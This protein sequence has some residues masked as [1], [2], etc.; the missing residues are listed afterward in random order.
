M[1]PLGPIPIE[2]IQ[3]ARERLVGTALRTPLLRLDV[4]DA[5]AEIWLKPEN[6][7]PGAGK[8]V[9]VISGGNIDA[10]KLATILS[11]SIP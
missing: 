11:G 1:N 4:D 6:L 2:A 9:C 10:T 3:A 7:Q 5:P 8:V